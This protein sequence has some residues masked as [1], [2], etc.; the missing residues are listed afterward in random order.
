MQFYYIST[1]PKVFAGIPL[2]LP[3]GEKVNKGAWRMPWLTEAMK[4]AISCDKLRVGA[5]NP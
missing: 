4:D 2:C 5:N 3:A 1:Q